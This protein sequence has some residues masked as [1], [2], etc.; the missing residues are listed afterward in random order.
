LTIELS[1]SHPDVPAASVKELWFPVNHDSGCWKAGLIEKQ[2]QNHGYRII[3]AEPH[4][5]D[6]VGMVL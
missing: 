3:D 2:Y 6:S 4:V 1:E 5:H